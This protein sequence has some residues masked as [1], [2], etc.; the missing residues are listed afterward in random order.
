MPGQ[1]SREGGGGLK[2]RTTCPSIGMPGHAL[3]LAFFGLPKT[4]AHF[5]I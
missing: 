4:Q 5:I 1:S 3:G 2:E